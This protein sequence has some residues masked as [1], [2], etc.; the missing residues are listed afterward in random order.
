[1]M[2]KNGLFLIQ[3]AYQNTENLLKELSKMAQSDDHIVVM[4]DSV[5]RI[6]NSLLDAFP[7]LYCLE[8]EQTLLPNEV[9][10]R[11]LMIDYSEFANL[12]IQFER[13]ISLK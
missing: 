3:A 13:C 1:M 4:G 10:D 9:K 6:T 2:K 5:L 12:V 8:N 7:N 11:V